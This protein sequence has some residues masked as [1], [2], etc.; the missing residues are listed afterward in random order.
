MFLLVR[1]N[2]I[3]LFIFI[4]FFQFILFLSFYIINNPYHIVFIRQ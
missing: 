2:L 1:K 4:Y 3:I